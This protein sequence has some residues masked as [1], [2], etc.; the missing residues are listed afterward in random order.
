MK[1]KTKHGDPKSCSWRGIRQTASQKVVTA[2]ARRRM[3]KGLVRGALV[4]VALVTLIFGTYLSVGYWKSGVERVNT[5]LPSQP[6]REIVFSTDG[7][8]SSGWAESTLGLSK[9][10]EV[11]T[12]DIHRKKM[13]LEEHGQ[14][15]S[16]VVR[17]LPDRLL[18]EVQE[19]M[20]VVRLAARDETGEVVVHLV[21]RDGFVYRGLGYARHELDALPF[22]AGIR[23]QRSTA[24]FQ[25]LEGM[26]Q[27]DDLLRTAR[28][29]IPHL[30]DVWNVVDCGDLP[31]IKIRSDDFKEIVFGPGRVAEQLRMLD[32][33]VSSNRR[34]MLGKR[35]RVDLSLGNQ[36]V[37]R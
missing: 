7:V 20:P 17:R 37:V 29:E 30:S 12:I 36:V 21:D 23:L 13:L 31:L 15:K 5:A 14:V 4:V 8:L 18:V 26:A 28:Y 22:L 9:G 19:R 34:Q 24:G 10:V 2:H 3:L 1:K 11:M 6:L 16:A 32:M 33:I 27:V 25:P 35:D